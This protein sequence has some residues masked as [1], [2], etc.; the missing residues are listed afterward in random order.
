[1]VDKQLALENSTD[2][3]INNNYHADTWQG[4]SY[5]NVS[6]VKRGHYS[7]TVL[8]VMAQQMLLLR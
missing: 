2:L 7:E 8:I 6:S 4:S 5:N 3:I 1:M